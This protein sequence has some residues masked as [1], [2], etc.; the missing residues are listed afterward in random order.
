MRGSPHSVHTNEESP[1]ADAI[2]SILVHADASARTT[3]R[4]TLAQRLAAEHAAQV[5]VLHAVQPALRTL[6]YEGAALA[7]QQLLEMDE[8]QK[9]LSRKRFEQVFGAS[10]A[11]RFGAVQALSAQAE[12]TRQALYADLVVLGQ[13]EPAGE[14]PGMPA[15]FIEDV[16]TGCGRPVLVVPYAGRFD[17]PLECAVVAWKETP[18]AARALAGAMPLLRRARQVHV[19]AFGLAPSEVEDARLEMAGTLRLHGIEPVIHAEPVPGDPLG[20]LI[21]SRV[22]DLGG[23]LLVMGCYGHSRARERILG[24]VSRTLLQSMTVPVLMAH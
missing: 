12:F 2:R 7:A 21:L 4:L 18:E 20:D 14:P 22:A 23:D 5:T 1:M 15:Q 6:P 11:A 24:G 3:E 17:R 13:H 16:V 10:A 19:L 9:G 8:E